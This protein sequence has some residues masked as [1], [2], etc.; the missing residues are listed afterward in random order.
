MINYNAYFGS[1]N[2]ISV[3]DNVISKNNQ[4]DI[5]KIECKYS[6]FK[7]L[8]DTI[9]ADEELRAY[10]QEFN[11]EW[12]EFYK[13]KFDKGEIN[14]IKYHRIINNITQ[15]KLA[16][17]LGIEQSNVS[18]LEKLKTTDGISLKKAKLIAQ[19]LN[20]SVGEL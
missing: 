11:A 4:D 14:S 7:N 15:E 3:T 1:H 20:I 17:L 16:V 18:R 2:N 10:S 5:I 9:N 13:K 6:S 19:A 8:L 12:K